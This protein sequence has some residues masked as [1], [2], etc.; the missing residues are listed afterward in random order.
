MNRVDEIAAAVLCLADAEFTTGHT[1]NVDGGYVT[2]R[3]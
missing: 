3:A 1:V 2:A